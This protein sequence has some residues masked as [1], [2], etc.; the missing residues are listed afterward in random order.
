MHQTMT[1]AQCG[2][3]ELHFGTIS[4]EVQLRYHGHPCQEC[5]KGHTDR[6]WV[7]F[8]SPECLVTYTAEKG[9]VDEVGRL[10]EHAKT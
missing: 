3:A 5:H 1:C 4:V 9:F 8:C 6:T 2:K 7:L 10:E